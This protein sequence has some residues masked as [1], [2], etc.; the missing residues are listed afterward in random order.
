MPK[1]RERRTYAAIFLDKLRELGGDEIRINNRT[2]RYELGWEDNEERYRRI[3]D[4]LIEQGYIQSVP[5]GPS[6]AVLLTSG[7]EPETVKVRPDDEEINQERPPINIFISYC[8]ADA[9]A[10]AEL[11]RQLNPLTYVYSLR[12]WEDGLIQAGAEWDKAIRDQMEA[13]DIILLL[14]SVDFINSRYCLGVELT[15]AL[16]RH[17]DKKST[18]IPVIVRDCYWKIK[19]LQHLQALPAEARPIA[20]WPDKDVVYAQIAT[21][22]EEILQRLTR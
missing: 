16:E 9:A 6:G 20:N 11:V 1:K 7:I 4:S 13:A 3:K 5:G 15:R 12:I 18:V 14:V 19:G 17:V 8:H 10:K 2:L 21:K 22:I